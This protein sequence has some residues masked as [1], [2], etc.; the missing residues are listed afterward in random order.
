MQLLLY[1]KC[2]IGNEYLTIK[3]SLIPTVTK[4]AQLA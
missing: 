2:E 1:E 3:M 4:S